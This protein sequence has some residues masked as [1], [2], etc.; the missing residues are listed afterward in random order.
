MEYIN[1]QEM[2][3]VTND[4]ACTIIEYISEDRDLNT[5]IA[6]IS[7]RHPISGW[8]INEKCKMMGFIVDGE[9]IIVVENKTF[10][11]FKND[12]VLIQPGEKYYWEGNMLIFIPSTPAWYPEQYKNIKD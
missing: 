10:E 8:A 9:G 5:C 2:A 12:V 4:P 1:A 3:A 11:L 6:K 7:G